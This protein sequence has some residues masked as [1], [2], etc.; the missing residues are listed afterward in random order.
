MI[1]LRSTK[2]EREAQVMHA[3]KFLHELLGN[4]THKL[5]KKALVEVVTATINTK[6][7][8]LTAIGRAMDSIQ[9]RSG[10]QKVNRLLGNPHLLMERKKIAL[11]VSDILISNKKH[12]SILVDWT[13]YPES[14]DVVL[15]A[16]LVAEGRSLTLYEERHSEKKL[17]NNRAQKRF[18]KELK[19]ILPPGCKPIIITD[20]GFHN[21]WFKEVLTYEWDYIGRI[22]G[23]K[24]FCWAGEDHFFKCSRLFRK[25]TETAK[26]IGE[27]VLTKKNPFITHL[28]LFKGKLKGRK[29]RTKRGKI[30]HD[31]DSKN[32]ARAQRE[33]WLLASSLKGRA[34]AKKV[35]LAYKF[36]MQIEQEFR[37]LKSKRYG[38]GLGESKTR[39]G[40]RRSILLLIGMLASLLAWLIGRAGERMGLH[41]QFQSNSIKTRR[42]ISLVYLGCQLVRKKIGIPAKALWESISLS[43]E[44]EALG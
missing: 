28:Y 12:P 19:E 44:E 23:M 32:Y 41:Y 37:D 27:V 22:R 40:N 6:K 1:S 29:A 5:R 14:K 25:A 9:E 30:K 11:R 43:H 8:V 35:I 38:F 21:D 16:S 15:R 17:G 42:V 18:L 24:K 39:I 2:K 13:K 26:E 10:I 31:K 3:K 7:L 34:A 36:R 4:V 33:P 20:A